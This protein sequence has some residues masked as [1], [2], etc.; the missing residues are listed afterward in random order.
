VRL[1]GFLGDN[2]GDH[3][4]AAVAN[5]LG[6]TG[7]HFEQAV[8]ADGL[9]AQAI[10]AMLLPEA[11]AAR[12]IAQDIRMTGPQWQL[13]DWD[14]LAQAALRFA[15]DPPAALAPPMAPAPASPPGAPQPAA[16]QQIWAL[17]ASHGRGQGR[18]A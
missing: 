11:Q 13:A 17:A 9:T 16:S 1:L 12:V 18:V 2:V 4:R 8:F 3:L 14:A 6:D 15:D 5:V 7:L 10:A